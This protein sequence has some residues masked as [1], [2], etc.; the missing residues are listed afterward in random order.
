MSKIPRNLQGILWSRNISN[1]DLQR[2]KNYIIHQVLMYGS[3]KD[4]SWLKQTYKKNY[5][6]N[7]FI[8]EPRKL[9]TESGFNFVKNYLLNISE[10][11]NKAYY[12]KNLPRN[13]RS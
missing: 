11:L 7:I 1:L 6:K 13:I 8:N 9:Y 5:I 12:V 4:I 2:D 10:Q 3:L